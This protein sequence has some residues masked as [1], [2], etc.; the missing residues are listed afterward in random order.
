MFIAIHAS[1][2]SLAG[3]SLYQLGLIYGL[4]AAEACIELHV[5]IRA[6]KALLAFKG[7]LR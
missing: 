2:T 3:A 6:F 4:S 1:L 7:K 5:L